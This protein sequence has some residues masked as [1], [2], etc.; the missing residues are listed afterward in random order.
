MRQ[1]VFIILGT[2]LLC[3]FTVGRAP[4]RVRRNLYDNHLDTLTFGERFSLKANAVDWLLLTPSIGVEFTLGNMNWSRWTIGV[5][6][7]YKPTMHF[8]TPPNYSYN[9]RDFRFDV[10][11]Y[12][13]GRNNPRRS[14]FLGAYGL[15]GKHDIKLGETGYRGNHIG[16]GVTAG[17]IMPLFGYRNGSSLD[18]E[19]STSAGILFAKQE[20]YEKQD[21]AYVIL[22]PATSYAMTW[23][24]LLHLAVHDV[25]RVCLVYHFGPSVANRYKRRIA[26]D[27]RYRL[28][29]S[30]LKMR[31][32]STRQARQEQ[33]EA[34]RDSLELVD[35][36]RRF[37]KQRHALESAF[38]KDSLRQAQKIEK[39]LARQARQLAK[40]STRRAKRALKDSLRQVRQAARDSVRQAKAARRKLKIQ[41]QP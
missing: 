25:V 30:E 7:R 12:M 10:R 16:A 41:Q 17:L 5:H 28:H 4:E 23:K 6:G 1:W 31:R 33:R 32:D 9:L 38:V 13:H 22:S 3:S 18:L 14:Y 37:E 11:R 19:L 20:E 39:A 40:D 29:L 24:P 35:Y 8:D 34:R 36:E 26:I 21:N 15:I 27:E 2:L